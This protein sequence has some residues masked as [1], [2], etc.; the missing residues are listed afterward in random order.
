LSRPEHFAAA[1]G[2]R[3]KLKLKPQPGMARVLRGALRSFEQDQLSIEDE[4]TKNV[5]QIPLG[6]VESARIDFVFE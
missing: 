2:E 3:L 5:L 6:Q 1:L 4:A